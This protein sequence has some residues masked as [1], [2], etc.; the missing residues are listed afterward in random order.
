M[1]LGDE[2]IK[3]SIGSFSNDDGDANENVK[4]Y[5]IYSSLAHAPILII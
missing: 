2:V 5:P 1:R 3:A 4:M